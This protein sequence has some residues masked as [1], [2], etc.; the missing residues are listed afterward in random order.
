[1][2]TV[3]TAP[4]RV[5][6]PKRY[7]K[8]KQ[9]LARGHMSPSPKGESEKVD[10]TKQ[11]TKVTSKIDFS[12]LGTCQTL[13][14]RP[15]GQQ[16][17]SDATSKIG[18]S[19]LGTCQT[20]RL[21]TEWSNNNFNNLHFIFSLNQPD[22]SMIQTRNNYLLRIVEMWAVEMIVEPLHEDVTT[23]AGRAW[24]PSSRPERPSR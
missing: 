13:R 1:M 24:R 7:P 16:K 12:D 5:A 14:L 10:P 18:F 9:C 11:N 17:S 2:T 3:V 22:S 21:F 4:W 8:T 23:L 20:L 15:A 19:D 6:P